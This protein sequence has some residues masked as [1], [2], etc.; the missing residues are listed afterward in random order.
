MAFITFEG[1][2]G[3][4]KT[5][6]ARLLHRVLASRGVDTLLTREPGGCEVADAIRSIL[7]DAAHSELV[8]TTELL[9]YAAAR[10]QHVSQVIRPALSR[11]MVVICDRFTDAT[12][13]YQGFGRG[14]DRGL[15]RRL[16]DI[17]APA[18]RPDVTVLL[19][20]PVDVGLARAFQRMDAS[21]APREERFELE[22]KEF[23]E[24]VREGYRWLARKEPDRFIVVDA[25]MS[26]ELV[27][28]AIRE[29]LEASIPSLF[30]RRGTS[31]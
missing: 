26:V 5:T 15:I 28:Q 16:N 14:L 1:S 17:A 8:P 31:S 4:G 30:G 7:L 22:T 25:Q 9:L 18:L 6:Q 29:R 2:E 12:I 27:H 13:A 19:D 20:L 21:T 11:G 24:R 10:A 23:H 3:C